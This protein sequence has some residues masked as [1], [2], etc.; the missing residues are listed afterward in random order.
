MNLEAAKKEFGRKL[1]ESGDP[2]QEQAVVLGYV[3]GA[4]VCLMGWHDR[5][6]RDVRSVPAHGNAVDSMQ[7]VLEG[8]MEI[9]YPDDGTLVA[10][11]P[12]DCHVVPGGKPHACVS[13]RRTLVLVIVG[14]GA[15]DRDLG[16]ASVV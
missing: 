12:S 11:G 8:G 7:I 14:Y 13:S 5:A 4:E 1:L 10:L 2:T 16:G 15:G 3:G 6:A 9:L